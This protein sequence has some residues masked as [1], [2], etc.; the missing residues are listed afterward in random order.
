MNVF[1]ENTQGADLLWFIG[2]NFVARSYRAHFKKFQPEKDENGHFIKK[3]FEFTA[4]CNS[5][6]ASS[7]SNILARL[8][9]T[10]AMATNSNKRSGLMA[11]YII[12]VLDDDLISYLDFAE[13]G[14]ATLL[15]TWIEWLASAFRDLIQQRLKQLPDKSKKFTPF[16]YWVAALT[17]AYFDKVINQQRIKFNLSLESVIRARENENKRVMKLKDIWNSKDSTLI[18]NNRMSEP[19]LTVYWSAIDASFMYN[20]LRREIFIAKQLTL[21]ESSGTKAV[22]RGDDAQNEMD[23]RADRNNGDVPERRVS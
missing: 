12:V 14:M 17:H 8:Q 22:T 7:Q 11:R 9:D 5:R 4:F 18:I 16:L 15:G 20:S 2:D 19:G 10:F 1:V 13:D 3:N 6:F 23:R 21:S